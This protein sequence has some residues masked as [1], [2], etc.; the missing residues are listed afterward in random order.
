MKLRSTSQNSSGAENIG[1]C[2]LPAKIWSCAP[3]M[4]DAM[5]SLAAHLMSW[6]SAP[7][8]TRIRIEEAEY[9]LD[10]QLAAALNG[11]P[12]QLA[13]IWLAEDVPNLQTNQFLN[14][15]PTKSVVTKRH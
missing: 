6:S 12:L 11:D 5:N 14:R 8:A 1:L 9:C 15:A 10:W 7:W 4:R 3:G 2:P 13:G